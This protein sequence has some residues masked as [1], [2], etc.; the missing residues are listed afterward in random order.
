VLTKTDSKFRGKHVS[1]SGSWRKSK[2]MRSSVG[3]GSDDWLGLRAR[4]FCDGLETLL[5]HE[6]KIIFRVG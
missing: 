5:H 3:G 4:D 6:R 2:L 1:S